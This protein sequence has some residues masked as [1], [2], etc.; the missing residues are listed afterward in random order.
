[1]LDLCLGS[2]WFG[3]LHD[4]E[5]PGSQDSEGRKIVVHASPMS[6]SKREKGSIGDGAVGFVTFLIQLVVSEEF[7]DELDFR[8][9]VA[10]GVIVGGT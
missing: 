3:I 10:P 4:L 6:F 5:I 1:M 9:S 2:W 8:E 7:P